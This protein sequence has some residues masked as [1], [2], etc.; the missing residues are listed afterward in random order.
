MKW[1]V[2]LFLIFALPCP[3]LATD[4]RGSCTV[5][6]EGSSTLHDFEGNGRCQPF[7]VEETDEIMHVPALNVAVSGMETGNDKRDQKMR[8]MFEAEQ[9][10]LITGTTG[11]IPLKDFRMA[12][13]TGSDTSE[14]A[15]QLQIRDIT[16]P[17]VARVQN[18]VM[19]AA[20]IT[21]DLNFSLSL[22]DYQLKPPSVL[23][24]IRVGDQ[25]NVSV[26]FVL[27]PQ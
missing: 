2:L 6:F 20:K 17:V 27:E 19:T 16:K 25:V 18:L 10:P 12:Q 23:G 1:F 4:Y 9:F 14:V 3:S 15:M 11:P 8:E 24:I 22:A 21:A 5:V 7:T 26:S 13:A